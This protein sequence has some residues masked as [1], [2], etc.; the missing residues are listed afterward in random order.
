MSILF[1]YACR[2]IIS[3]CYNMV[4]FTYFTDFEKLILDKISVILANQG[5]AKKQT[6]RI[7]EK[8]DFLLKKNN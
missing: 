4:Y 8:V 3:I 7:E 1:N 5:N 6:A 2:Y